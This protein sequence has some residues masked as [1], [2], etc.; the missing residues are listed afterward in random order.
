MVNLPA[1]YGLAR[2]GPFP[3]REVAFSCGDLTGN[4]LTTDPS[5]FPSSDRTRIGV[6]GVA[7]VYLEDR[8]LAY[9][10]QS[11]DLVRYT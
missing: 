7:M 5:L 4:Q 11:S 8:M 10:T 2:G 3:D 9:S 6:G 1:Q